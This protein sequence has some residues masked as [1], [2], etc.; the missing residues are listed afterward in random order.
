M[1]DI[2]TLITLTPAFSKYPISSDTEF[3]TTTSISPKS[4]KRKAEAAAKSD[5]DEPFDTEV[6]DALREWRRDKAG[7]LPAYLIYPDRTLKELARVK[8]QTMDQLLEVRGIGEAKAKRFGEATLA[9]IR[10]VRS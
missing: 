1:F 5:D 2:Q 7:G 8:P 4:P 9:V 6:F 3:V 10:R